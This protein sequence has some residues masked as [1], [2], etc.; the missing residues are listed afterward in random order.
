MGG[1]K[2]K[3]A[4][5]AEE[6]GLVVMVVDDSNTIRSSAQIFLASAGHRVVFAEDGF[7]ALAAVEDF[8]PDLIFMDAMM[9][10]LD[11]YQACRL[12]KSSESYKDIP[13][14]MLTGRAG[15]FDRARGALAGASEHIA[16]PFTK[17]ALLAA[18]S[19]HAHGRRGL[20]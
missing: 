12:I 4:F 15:V 2:A 14:V 18:V 5:M 10:R 11:G 19:R 9:D 8:K 16:K 7:A 17:E 6:L 20:A 13:I 3:G 1:I